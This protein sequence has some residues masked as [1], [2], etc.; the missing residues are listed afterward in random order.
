MRSRKKSEQFCPQG[1]PGQ[2]DQPVLGSN[3]VF[4]RTDL[5][6]SSNDAAGAIA[7]CPPGTVAISGTY[8]G[9]GAPGISFM[10]TAPSGGN[11]DV[12]IPSTGWF[13]GAFNTG[14]EFQGFTVFTIYAPI[15][16]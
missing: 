3:L 4:G 14:P 6:I 15:V 11:P 13:V 7:N 16:E 10:E 8:H 1:P 12:G 2:I 9:S 5:V